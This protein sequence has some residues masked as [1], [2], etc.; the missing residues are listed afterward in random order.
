MNTGVLHVRY[1][2]RGFDV[3]LNR[4]GVRQSAVEADEDRIKTAL[5]KHLVVP[6]TWLK[7]FVMQRHTDGDVTL[8]L[9]AAD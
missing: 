5:A 8:R 1:V 2:N 9:I 6:T 4:L 7:E 3:P